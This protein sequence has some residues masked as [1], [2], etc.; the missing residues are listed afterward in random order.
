MSGSTMKCKYEGEGRYADRCMGTKE[1][2]PC[3]GYDK[4]AHFKPNFE[5]NS[6]HI[7]SMTDEEW[8]A[9]GKMFCPYMKKFEGCKFGWS[10][11]QQTCEECV[12]EWLKAPYEEKVE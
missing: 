7:R 9:T 11:P 8:V 10:L 3:P 12:L 5:S 4:C 1:I 2:D 6:D